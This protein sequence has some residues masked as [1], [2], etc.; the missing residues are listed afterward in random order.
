MDKAIFRISVILSLFMCPVSAMGAEL[1]REFNGTRSTETLEF[2]VNGPWVLDW[3]L[4]TDFPGQ[5]GVDITLIRAGTGAYE[6]S[7]LKTKWPGNGVRLFESSGKFQFKIV[8]HLANWT[9]KVEQLTREEA[10]AYTP[11]TRGPSQ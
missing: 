7:V 6:G 4:G 1:V 8:S 9:L 5:M 11:K 2:E 10:K 3:R